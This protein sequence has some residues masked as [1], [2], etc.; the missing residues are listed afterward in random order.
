VLCEDAGIN[1]F[2]LRN[3]VATD[4]PRLT[5]AQAF[6]PQLTSYDAAG[7]SEKHGDLYAATA[8]AGLPLIDV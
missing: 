8:A 5:A 3:D 6:R 4:V 1:A 2:F 7:D